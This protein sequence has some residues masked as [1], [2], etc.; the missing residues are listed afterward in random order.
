MDD[1]N[2]NKENSIHKESPDELLGKLICQSTAEIQDGY[3]KELPKVQIQQIIL[4]TKFSAS[5]QCNPNN[6]S[7]TVSINL[8]LP[9]FRQSFV[10]FGSP[11]GNVSNNGQNMNRTDSPFRS[12]ESF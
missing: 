5:Q 4:Q 1:L 7:I 12:Y 10:P 11:P 9:S 8:M 3:Q 6:T 2:G